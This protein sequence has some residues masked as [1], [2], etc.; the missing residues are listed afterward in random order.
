LK[1]FAIGLG[2]ETNSFC[3]LPTTLQDFKND[4]FEGF[5]AEQPGP[6]TVWQ[7][8]AADCGAQFN[9]GSNLW[10]YPAGP[11]SAAAFTVLLQKLLQEIQH[12]GAVDILLLNLHGAM[13]A[14]GEDD[15]EGALLAAIQDCIDSETIVGVLIDPHA[16]L[17]KRMLDNSDI[18]IAY[19]EFPHDDIA[20][21]AGEL[22]HLCSAAASGITRPVMAFESANI[23]SMINTKISPGCDLVAETKRIERHT[24]V[25]SASIIQGFAW[26]D[27]P[28]VGTRALVV[29][30]GNEA[31][32]R[33]FSSE[34]VSSLRKVR[35]GIAIGLGALEI[36]AAIDA[37]ESGE[38][39]AA[40][41][42][43]C[44]PADNITGGGAGDA[45]HILER[46][47]ARRV[48]F[49]C[50]AALWDPLA[51]DIVTK[52]GKGSCLNLRMGGK[53]GQMAGQPVD[54]EVEVIEIKLAYRHIV[55]AQ[56]DFAA[57]DTVHVRTADG[58]D[59]I[60]SALRYPVLSPSIFT[61]F[62][63]DLATK[64]LVA[65]KGFQMAR[66]QF[67]KVTH[68]FIEVITDG[69]MSSNVCSLPYKRASRELWPLNPDG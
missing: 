9:R 27:G 49:A 60:L 25:L 69:A 33:Q 22:F 13:M 2:T 47:I 11:V 8:M 59:I 54:A 23:L 15:C 40:P 4:L 46:L 34:L 31:L 19:K 20:D 38:S 1:V 30:N 26:G 32:A 45:T 10:A 61:D 29:A 37:V 56:K 63:I 55:S 36:N 44:E 3:P 43:L 67:T 52:A 41:A 64:K 42:V 7:R 65:I 53:S 39:G 14:L 12:N 48:R 51:V 35:Q 62:G 24:D 5:V 68:R 18:I 58:L 21:R 16:H 57:G 6:F 66:V 17:T 50:F 28:D